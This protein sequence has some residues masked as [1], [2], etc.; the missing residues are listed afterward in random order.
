MNSDPT[1]H[2]TVVGDAGVGKTCMIQSLLN[3]TFVPIYYPTEFNKYN[4]MYKIKD[5]PNIN[6]TIWY[7]IYE[8]K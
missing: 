3:N 1:V 8:I 2:V 5:G 4:C 7:V 6:L